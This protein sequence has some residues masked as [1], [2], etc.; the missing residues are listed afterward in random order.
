MAAAERR[1]V[2]ASRAWTLGFILLCACGS[3]ELRD[4]LVSNVAAPTDAVATPSEPSMEVTQGATRL[5]DG[6]AVKAVVEVI[7]D[8][9]DQMP[10]VELESTDPKVFEVTPWSRGHFYVLFGRRR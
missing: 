6:I 5:V 4:V 7:D 3:D 1:V 10:G 2:R 9:G 8:D